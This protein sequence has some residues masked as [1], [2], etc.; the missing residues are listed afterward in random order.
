MN[1]A[2]LGSVDPQMGGQNLPWAWGTF[3][4]RSLVAN[5][6]LGF[7]PIILDS[8]Y[9]FE[10][11]SDGQSILLPEL[12][13]WQFFVSQGQLATSIPANNFNGRFIVSIVG[14][15]EFLVS[16]RLL[17]STM[18]DG[19]SV[20]GR[21]VDFSSV[22]RAYFMINVPNA[23]TGFREGDIPRWMLTKIGD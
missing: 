21:A 18:V 17:P 15:T 7:S 13:I 4:N 10:I 9:D 16:Q 19:S 1:K 2:Y 8:N 22:P 11:G 12:G 14:A 23:Q 20:V 6:W 5:A 3:L